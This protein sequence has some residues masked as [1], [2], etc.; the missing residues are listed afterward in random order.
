MIK[1]HV[2][3]RGHYIEQ[4]AVAGRTVLMANNERIKKSYLAMD[5]QN[6]IELELKE[7]K[8]LT[9]VMSM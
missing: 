6:E 7:R 1:C 8:G 5:A 3:I 4:N 2:F 9:I